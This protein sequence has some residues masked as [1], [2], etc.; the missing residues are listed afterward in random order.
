[1]VVLLPKRGIK[2]TLIE[3]MNAFKRRLNGG[4]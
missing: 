1:M 4:R 3:T 2:N